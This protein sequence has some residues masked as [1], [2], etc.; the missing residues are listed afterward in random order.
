MFNVIKDIDHIV[1]AGDLG[2]M[3]I[4]D[5]LNG[6]ETI[7][8]VRGNVYTGVLAA[9]LPCYSVADIAGHK[10]HIT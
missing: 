7:S 1:H 10:L 9:S 5:E 2:K 4:L 8:V 3:E 6:I